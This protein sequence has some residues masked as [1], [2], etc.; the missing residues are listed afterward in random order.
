MQL[1]QYVA[2][3]KCKTG[4]TTKSTSKTVSIW[5]C[6]SISKKKTPC[7]DSQKQRCCSC[8]I[9]NFRPIPSLSHLNGWIRG[10]SVFLCWE[11]WG[12]GD[13]TA[14]WNVKQLLQLPITS[15]RTLPETM[16][17]VSKAER[18]AHPWEA[19]LDNK[20]ASLKVK[21]GKRRF[22]SLFWLMW[23]TEEPPQSNTFLNL[24]WVGG[25]VI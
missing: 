18:Q 17:L 12:L 4:A 20:K 5:R 1:R 24:L 2:Q 21:E 16:Q 10:I 13:Y 15:A 23:S 14:D 6:T 11:R 8:Y 7:K 9:A 19:R 25:E 3:W 22:L